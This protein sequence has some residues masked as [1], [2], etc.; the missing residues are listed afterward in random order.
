[1]AETVA[2]ANCIQLLQ[3]YS[4]STSIQFIYLFFFSKLNLQSYIA[5][6]PRLIRKLEGKK[7]D[8]MIIPNKERD[9]EI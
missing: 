4:T 3:V 2:K 9:N 6:G 1:M 7:N 8:S 5:L